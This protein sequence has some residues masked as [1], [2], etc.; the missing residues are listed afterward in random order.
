[1]MK[2]AFLPASLLGALLT[3]CAGPASLKHSD[4]PIASDV[5]AEG[6]M[7]GYVVQ[8]QHS[9][10]YIENGREVRIRVE[11]GWDYDRGTGVRRTFDVD[12]KLV[13]SEDLSGADVRLGAIEAQRVRALVLGHPILHDVVS[14][15]G[16]KLWTEG[17]AYR[18]GG[19]RYCGLGSRC[20]HAIAS[21]G[22]QDLTPVAHAIVDLQSDRVVYPFYDGLLAFGKKVDGSQEETHADTTGE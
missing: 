10:F 22:P 12:G 2:T 1:M 4:A 6:R 7:H 9:D 15:P 14:E 18:V 16:V 11:Y 5:P 13:R 19:D 21:A 8:R 3:A 20:I 17:F